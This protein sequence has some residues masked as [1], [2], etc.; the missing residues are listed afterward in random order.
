MDPSVRECRSAPVVWLTG[1]SSAGKTT[2]SRN[3]A[4]HLECRGCRVEVLDGDEVRQL[5]C[6]DLGFSKKDRDE[7]IRRIGY[8]AGLLAKHGVLV[9]VSAISP[10][11]DARDQLRRQIPGFFEV[12][13]NAPLHVC[14]GRDV[15]GLYQKSRAGQIQGLT[16]VDDPYE[17]PL[18]PEVECRTECE[19]IEESVQKILDFLP[20]Q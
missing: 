5:L 4:H 7:N 8:V 1:L 18:N 20:F 19:T 16:G 14:E 12:Y 11:R 10:Y 17:P 2:L 13:V 15:K 6:K 9:I 3:L